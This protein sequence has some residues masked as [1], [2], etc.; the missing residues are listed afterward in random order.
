MGDN[1]AGSAPDCAS[2][3]VALRSEGYNLIGN[4]D[5]CD[6]A[7]APGDLIG[8]P[9]G[10]GVVD[11]KLGILT[12]RGGPTET[13]APAPSSPAINQIPIGALSADGLVTLCPSAGIDQRG[14][15]RPQG[16]GCDIGS[17][18]TKF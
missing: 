8:S 2:P 10:G 7:A 14:K 13:M 9:S 18:E 3:Y 6:V 4:A 16:T 5:G 1:T 15:P 12:A 17:Y 11:P